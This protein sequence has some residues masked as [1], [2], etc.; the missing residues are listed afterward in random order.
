[1]FFVTPW[2]FV[3]VLI[4][5]LDSFRLL[6]VLSGCFLIQPGLQDKAVVTWKKHNSL[7]LR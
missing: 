2:V 7:R 1:M 5:T 6:Y 4:Y 3:L